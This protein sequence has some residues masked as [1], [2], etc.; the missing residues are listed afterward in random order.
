MTLT[1]EDVKNVRFPIAKRQGEGYRATEV[2]D[3]V[4][5]VDLTFVQMSEENERLRAQLDALGGDRETAGDPTNSSALADE[6]ARLQAEIEALRAQSSNAGPALNA[7]DAVLNDSVSNDSVS[8]DSVDAGELQRLREENAGLRSELDAAR[9]EVEQAR[10]EV[11]QV[12]GEL[13]AARQATPLT[14]VDGDGAGRVEKIVVTTSAQA[15][16]AVVRMV[17]LH[18]EQAETLV[19]EAEA[20]AQ[21]KVAEADARAQ[22]AVSEAERRAHELTVDA[23]TRAERIQSE[24]RVNADQLAN[25]AKAQA[26]QLTSEAAA[27][28]ERVHADAEAR[29]S[30]LFSA[31]EAERDA[32]VGKVDDLRTYEGSYRSTLTEHLRGQIAHLENS[33]FEPEGTPVL[34]GEER[35]AIA[36]QTPR[37]DAL[38]AEGNN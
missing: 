36:S 37:L 5:A 9:K 13:D 7:S 11:S 33:T 29:R 12:R 16:P 25:E 30:E 35:P 15:S 28:S 38:L 8:N 23:Q 4:D 31:L 10:A 20:E 34:L 1:L 27:N 19:S 26:D 21:R 22:Q 32:L 14:V 18:T 3:F 17:Q 24:A 2:D 6:N